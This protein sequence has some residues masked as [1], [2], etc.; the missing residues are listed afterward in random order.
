MTNVP[1]AS[2]S[3]V[4]GTALSLRREEQF[5]MALTK[6]LSAGW[7]RFLDALRLD[8]RQ[9]LVE[10]LREE[11]VDEVKDVA[12]FEEHA[13][14][15][16]YPHFRAR[17]LAIAEEEK[18]HVEWL[19]EKIRAL[20][21]EVPPAAPGVKEGRNP[22]E[23]LLMDV[24]EEKRDR[25]EALERLYAAAQNADPEIA[26]GLRRIH[27]DEKRHREEI[28]EMLMRTDPQAFSTTTPAAVFESKK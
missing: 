11:Y 20:G 9:R 7:R 1:T 15:M 16:V 14:R 18:A 12:Q 13:R 24:E 5:A 26:E 2:G 6:V 10:F 4:C 23:N 27:E 28:L 25:I 17:L 22:W 19:R 8:D 21:G 3:G